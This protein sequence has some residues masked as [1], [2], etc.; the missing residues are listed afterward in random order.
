M[1]GAG[2]DA[3]EVGPGSQGMRP[4][5]IPLT[6]AHVIAGTGELADGIPVVL[7]TGGARATFKTGVPVSPQSA[8]P[9]RL[10]RGRGGL[11]GRRCQGI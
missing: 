9:H 5:D 4:R 3:E 11:P 1:Y 10:S 7:L 2:D 6:Q 8:R